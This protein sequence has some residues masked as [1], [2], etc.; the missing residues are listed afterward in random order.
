MSTWGA[1]GGGARALIL[2]S[3]AVLALGSGYLGWTMI[4]PD[5]PPATMAGT[6]GGS[7]PFAAIETDQAA[8]SALPL[9]DTWRVAPDGDALIAGLAAPKAL[10]EVLVDGVPVASG[11]AGASGEFVLQFTLAAND[12]PSLM[13]LAMTP[14]EGAQ[15]VSD[16]VVALAPIAGPETA[17]AP[18]DEGGGDAP[19]ALMLTGDGAV[20]LQGESTTDPVL[21]TNVMIDTI[22]YTSLGE[23]QIGG[24]GMPGAGLHVYLDT[25][26]ETSLVVPETGQWLLTLTDTP[27]GIYTLRVDQIDAE[28]KIISR[29]ETPF[30]RE[31]LEDLALVAG[32]AVPEPAPEPT[33]KVTAEA[34][35]DP[36]VSAVPG[37]EPTPATE[38]DLADANAVETNG[39]AVETVAADPVASD[40]V[41]VESVAADT[42]GTEPVVAELAAAEPVPTESVAKALAVAAPVE[43]VVDLPVTPEPVAAEVP[44]SVTVTVQPGFTLWGI[45]QQRYGDGV[46]Y[47]QVFEANRDKIKDPDMI[48][49]GQVF[50]VPAGVMPTP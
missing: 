37:T 38:M 10:V 24:R 18:K 40:P 2:G 1:L 19:A 43:P 45:A 33:D 9:I 26:E 30:K 31:R 4:Q 15:I 34:A 49:P 44:P 46:L 20:V 50:A 8:V 7:L 48:F 28:G 21:K 17:L 36:A 12:K 47:V 6:D 27:P 41:V 32:I 39:V 22:A 11:L 25:V 3:G 14:P 5:K 13:T 29:F 16:A 23:V 42:V 35:S